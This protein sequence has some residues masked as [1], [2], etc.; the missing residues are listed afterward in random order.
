MN[1]ML[2]NTITNFDG[3]AKSSLDSLKDENMIHFINHMFSKNFS[4]DSK[5]T[6]ISTESNATDL[7]QKRCD[8]LLK[9]EDEIFLIEIQSYDDNEMA[10]R[11]FDY[12]FRGA[13]LHGKN[14]AP[15]GV[16]E[17]NF[18]EPAV[19]YLR[20]GNKVHD[21]LSIRLRIAPGKTIDY[22]AR[23]IYIADYS[24]D[25]ML[26]NYMFPMIPFYSMRY[27]NLLFN[28]HTEEDEKKILSDLLDCSKKLKAAFKNEIITGETYHYSREWFVKVFIG[29]I[30]KA[31]K[32]KTFV[33]EKEAYRVMQMML[34]EP[35]EG[36]DIFKALRESKSEGFEKGH[37]EGR[38]EGR[39]EGIAE[40]RISTARS[41]LASGV[42]DDIIISC[43]G[44]S[45]SDFEK[46]KTEYEKN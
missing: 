30:I 12:G 17:F 20:K 19:F 34:D 21:K 32:R 44:I 35:I 26:D 18:P 27:E 28:K 24:F 8:Y 41:L 6:R 37:E 15:D 1:N 14:I 13:E 3:I 23:V 43:T 29:I 25:N 11:I 22:C 7:K 16:Y 2:K 42:S 45:P 38:E 10:I 46:I 5:V 9:I 39:E 33:N 4:V 36:F 31:T 40:N